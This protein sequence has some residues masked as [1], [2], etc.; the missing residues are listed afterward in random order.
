MGKG[1]IITLSTERILIRIAVFVVILLIGL[2][3]IFTVEGVWGIVLAA[4][5]GITIGAASQWLIEQLDKLL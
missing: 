1:D 3:T 5:I 2:T 4:A